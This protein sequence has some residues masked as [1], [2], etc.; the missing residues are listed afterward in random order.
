LIREEV[1]SL[2]NLSDLGRLE[3]LMASLPERVGSPLSINSLR[4]DF[5]VSHQTTSRWLDVFER[6]YAI[7]RLPPFV[8]PRL[9]AVKKEQKHYHFDWTVIERRAARFEN[10][11]ASH[12]A[13]WVHFQWDVEGLPYELRYFRDSM[14]AKLTSLLCTTPDHG[15]GN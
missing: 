3:L 5:G 8:G 12:L 4:E 7:F 11:V 14:D 15:G 13:K 2:E 9:R 1:A 10:L 6:L